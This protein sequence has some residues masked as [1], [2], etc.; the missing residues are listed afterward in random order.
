MAVTSDNSVID[1]GFMKAFYDRIKQLFA[2]KQE[3]YV[4]GASITVTSNSDSGTLFHFGKTA[5]DTVDG[6]VNVGSDGLFI[7]KSVSTVY[8]NYTSGNAHI[9]YVFPMGGED[10]P[11]GK[12]LTLLGKFETGQGSGTYTIDPYA[13]SKL[14]VTDTVSHL[15]DATTIT[16]YADGVNAHFY[17]PFKMDFIYWNKQ[18]YSDGY[19]V[20]LATD[21]IHT[22]GDGWKNNL[23]IT[24]SGVSSLVSGRLGNY[25]PLSG[26]TVTGKLQNDYTA[27]NA[28]C[29]NKTNGD[30]KPRLTFQQGGVTAGSIGFDDSMTP[31]VAISGGTEIHKIIHDG[32]FEEEFNKLAVPKINE[33]AVTRGYV[34]D[35]NLAIPSVGNKS[36]DVNAVMYS[37]GSTSTNTPKSGYITFIISH[38]LRTTDNTKFRGSQIATI[39][40]GSAIS[41][42]AYVRNFFSDDNG[43]TITFGDWTKLSTSTDLKSYLPLSGGTMSSSSAAIVFPDSSSGKLTVNASNGM[44]MQA[45][46]GTASNKAFLL[47]SNDGTTDLFGYGIFA[48]SS[49]GF[50]YAWMGTSYTDPTIKILG[51]KNTG[52]AGSI[53][54][55]ASIANNN[56]TITG[57]CTQTY[58]STTEALEFTFN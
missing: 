13:Y 33:L 4:A 11:N 48:S 7:D 9:L 47:K 45:R 43:T 44:V 3:T 38:I 10:F 31:I 28:P 51:N 36:G 46:S 32:I 34:T 52:F 12:R 5:T 2:T 41:E 20:T 6:T 50:N 27:S 1:R 14:I 25:L 49:G 55:G 42:E 24:A 23:P 26:G 17:R 19:D 18:W 29:V 54:V 35:A 22:G 15:G 40:A 53:T 39:G 58:N 21:T 8:F 37:L 30:K 56:P 16:E 57:G